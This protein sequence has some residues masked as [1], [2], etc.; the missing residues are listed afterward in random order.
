MEDLATIRRI[1]LEQC[2]QFITFQSDAQQVIRWIHDTET[3][4]IR[5][6]TI[7]SC[8]QDAEQLKKEHEEFQVAIEVSTQ[9]V[10]NM[11]R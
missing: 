8:L 1:K 3:M 10:L 11:F 5:S 6:F 4:L 7:P 2:I 9:T